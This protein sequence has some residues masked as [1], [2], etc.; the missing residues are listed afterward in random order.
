MQQPSK[1]GPSP[2]TMKAKWNQKHYRG[3]QTV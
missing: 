3:E 1:S 2:K